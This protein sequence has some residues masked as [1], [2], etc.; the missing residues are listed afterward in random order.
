VALH[1]NAQ[2]AARAARKPLQRALRM[3]ELGQHVIGRLE[4]MLPGLGEAQAAALAP[5]QLGAE[6]PLQ[7]RN[8]VAERGLCQ[9]QLRRGRGQRAL[10]LDRAH[11]GEVTAFEHFHQ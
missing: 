10:R 6:P 11:D 8:G 5:P 3:L 7:L 2:A 1:A 4:Q 9:M